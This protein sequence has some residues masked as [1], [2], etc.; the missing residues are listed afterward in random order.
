MVADLSICLLLIGCVRQVI[1]GI[2]SRVGRGVV[3]DRKEFDQ[4]NIPSA[5]LKHD[6]VPAPAISEHYDPV[7]NIRK[8][9]LLTGIA[10]QSGN[11]RE[12]RVL[13]VQ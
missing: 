10:F 5:K 3:Q 7:D 9:A 11:K 6:P 1:T 8:E 12:V 4:A 13:L 2:K